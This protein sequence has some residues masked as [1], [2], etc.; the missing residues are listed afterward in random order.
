[1]DLSGDAFYYLGE[2]QQAISSYNKAIEIDVNN[3]FSWFNLGLTF[4]DLERYDHAT[5]AYN[6]GLK[7]A[8]DNSQAR[9][10]RERLLIIKQDNNS[11]STIS[12]AN[13][14]FNY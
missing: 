8:P 12:M 11:P 9:R 1:M 13:I 10:V 7:I 5:E 4:A 14:F 3:A 6:R 2:Y